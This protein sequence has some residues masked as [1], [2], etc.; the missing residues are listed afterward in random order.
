MLKAKLERRLQKVEQKLQMNK[1]Q[2]LLVRW[3]GSLS[4]N[5]KF[6]RKV[7]KIREKYPKAEIKIIEVVWAD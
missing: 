6:E 2:F 3:N 7:A 5:E 4:E 1:K